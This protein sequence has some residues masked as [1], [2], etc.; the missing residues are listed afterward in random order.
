M[1]TTEQIR[2]FIDTVGPLAAQV[3]EERGYGNAQAWTCVAQACCESGFGTSGIMMG[4]NAILGIK[5]DKGWVQAAKYGGLVYSARTKECYDGKTYVDITDAFRAYGSLI[6]SVRDYFD[7]I[8]KDRYKASLNATTVLECITIIKNGG[9]ATSP[10]YINTVHNNFYLPNKEQIES[11]KVNV[12]QNVSEPSS[13]SEQTSSESKIASFQFHDPIENNI[14]FAETAVFIAKNTK[15]FYVNGAWG[16][17]MTLA[18]KNRALNGTSYNKINANAIVS[19]PNGVYGWDCICLLKG[20]LWGWCNQWD[21]QYGGAG[22]ACNGV[23][24][25]SENVMIQRCSGVTSDFSLIHIGEMLWMDGHAGIYIGNGLAVECTPSWDNGVQITA[26]LNIDQKQGYNGRK[27]TKHGMLPYFRYV[28]GDI[29]IPE[30]DKAPSSDSSSN[31]NTS[32]ITNND[33]SQYTDEQLAQMVLDNK[34]GNNPKRQQLLGSRYRA[35]QDIVNRIV[36][37]ASASE[38]YVVKSGDT[39]SAIASKYGTTYQKIAADNGIANVNLIIVG[40]KLIIKK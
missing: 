2:S 18:N 33:L 32:I 19:L 28:D 25:L 11:Y 35:V 21:R 26:V 8:E 29:A 34:F 23:Q 10:T 22:Y 6:D 15:T 3:C 36:A 16:W 37:G 40:Q 20:I 5:A 39:L 17:P 9:Y 24:D 30:T 31:A 14:Q 12:K 13:N 38:V 1:A 4:A 7:L 27:W